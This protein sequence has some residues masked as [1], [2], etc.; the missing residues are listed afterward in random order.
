MTGRRITPDNLTTRRSS[1]RRSAGGRSPIWGAYLLRAIGLLSLAIWA[2]PPA[3]R[4]DCDVTDTGIPEDAAF[5]LDARGARQ[6]LANAGIGVGGTYYGESFGNWGGFKQGVD[7]DGVLELHLNAEM[8]RLG[9]WKGLCFH[10]NS[11]HGQSITAD[12]IGAIGALM[13]VSN[14]E[15][16]P[17]TRLDELWF[18]QHLFND[19]L[20]VKVGQLAAD[21]EFLISDG[22]TNF[23]NAAWGWPSITASDL[24]GGGPA[25][26]FATP[27]VRVALNPNDRFGLMIAVFNGDPAPPNCTGDPQECN[28]DG[29]DFRLDAPPLLMAEGAYKY[30][31]DKLGGTI[32]LGGW[33]HFGTFTDLRFD[34][35][36]S[37]VAVTGNPGRPLDNDW[38][39]YGIIDQLV[40]RLPGSEDPKGVGVFARFAGAPSDRNVVNFYAD[41]GITFTGMIPGRSDDALAIGFANTGISDQVHAFDVDS[42]EPVARNYEALIEICYTY[43]IKPGWTLQPDFQY[44]FQP[45]G[46][47]P[48]VDDAAV[49]GARTSISF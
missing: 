7:Y 19:K 32:K 35:R 8:R 10:V 11:F 47:V 5:K 21:T 6:A 43:Q 41:G 49:L 45:G 34:S 48:D 15:A 42:G 17:A 36:G 44:I 14:L 29:L 24:P 28:N 27:G 18:E 30:N 12:N 25:Y 3:A 46:N 38:G 1:S 16:T 37:P 26:P 22:G 39:L 31:Q 4:A 20:A 40:W 23:L 9:L 13:A 33:N 2:A